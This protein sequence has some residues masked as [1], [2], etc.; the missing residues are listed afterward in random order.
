MSLILCIVYSAE[1]TAIIFTINEFLTFI[2][3][4]LHNY[5]LYLYLF[6]SY[7]YTGS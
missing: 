1:M 4:L 3:T 2:A 6:D 5:T 7:I